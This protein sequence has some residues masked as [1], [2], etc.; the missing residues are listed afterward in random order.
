MVGTVLLQRTTAPARSIGPRA[1]R[2][3]INTAYAGFSP[4]GAGLADLDL[5][6]LGQLNFD[7]ELD[8]GE[9]GVQTGFAG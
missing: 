9:H 2:A 1:I 6:G 4:L 3:A 7:P 5:A 8:L